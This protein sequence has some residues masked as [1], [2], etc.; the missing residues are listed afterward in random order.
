MP[1]ANVVGLV[2]APARTSSIRAGRRVLGRRLPLPATSNASS[3]DLLGRRVPLPATSNA[4]GGSL[5]GRSL[6]GS[7]FALTRSAKESVPCVR[8]QLFDIVECALNSIGRLLA[9]PACRLRHA[10]AQAM[11]GFR[12]RRSSHPFRH[13]YPREARSISPAHIAIEPGAAVPVRRKSK[14]RQFAATGDAA[15]TAASKGEEIRSRTVS[16]RRR[17]IGVGDRKSHRHEVPPAHA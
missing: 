5:L 14:T 17:R 16:W 13:G 6:L 7:S 4:S 10:R 2:V 1:Y 15:A 12:H 3:A 11:P 8:N 9:P